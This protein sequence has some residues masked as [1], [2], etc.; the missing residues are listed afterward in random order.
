[1]HRWPG[2]LITMLKDSFD[3]Y[4]QIDFKGLKDLDGGYIR[5]HE[6]IA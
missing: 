2:L 4:K 1:M 6:K 3:N 5:N